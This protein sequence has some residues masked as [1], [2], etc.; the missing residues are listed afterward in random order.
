[1]TFYA[2]GRM[3][4]TDW[5]RSQVQVREGRLI[6]LEPSTMPTRR[7]RQ[8]ERKALNADANLCRMSPPE[9]DPE[10]AAT[11]KRKIKHSLRM[12]DPESHRPAYFDFP[13]RN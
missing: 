8:I 7:V 6:S 12:H 13:P 2:S 10:K 9:R 3:F 11:K 4:R 1:M 5:F